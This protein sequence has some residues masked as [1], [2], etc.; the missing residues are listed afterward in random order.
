MA[1]QQKFS[2]LTDKSC[3]VQKEAGAGIC[4]RGAAFCHRFSW[5]I[6][7]PVSLAS[8]GRI[9]A[10]IY[11]PLSKII[12]IHNPFQMSYWL[13]EA[14][15][16]FSIRGFYLQYIQLWSPNICLPGSGKKDRDIW[17]THTEIESD[18]VIKCP[19]WQPYWKFIGVA[20]CTAC[21]NSIGMFNII[22]ACFHCK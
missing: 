14:S 15:L 11:L 5:R 13:G 12:L 9:W 18:Q 6:I 17:K 2:R 8:R 19:L 7:I 21:A 1:Y 10:G 3:V 20:F 4:P 22:C 16:P